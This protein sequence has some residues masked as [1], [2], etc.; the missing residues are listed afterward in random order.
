MK[1]ADK[2]ISAASNIS[3]VFQG[4]VALDRTSTWRRDAGAG[5]LNLSSKLKDE[6][7]NANWE[8]VKYATAHE[9][10]IQCSFIALDNASILF[11]KRPSALE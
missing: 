6:G 5:A 4:T 11:F 2:R 7:T 10:H 3:I 1:N 8:I 9:R